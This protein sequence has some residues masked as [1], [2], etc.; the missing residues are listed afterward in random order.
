MSGF[1]YFIAD[2]DGYLKIGYSHDPQA[3]LAQLQTASRQ[4][5]RIITTVAGD[6]PTEKSLHALFADAH[7]RGEW[8]A[9]TE[10]LV[11]F[12]S[13]LIGF[14]YD[15]AVLGFD[16]TTVDLDLMVEVRYENYR[17]VRTAFE[18]FNESVARIRRTVADHGTV[19]AAF[20][21]G[22]FPPADSAKESAA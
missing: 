22:G 5:L 6:I 12:M 19:G 10:R 7:V 9:P 1:V 21:A 18:S 16:S 8:F 4:T 13:D 11:A 2:E 17:K 20:D 15:L 14:P 3:R